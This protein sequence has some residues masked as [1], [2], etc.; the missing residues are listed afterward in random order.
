M[1]ATEVIPSKCLEYGTN[2]P[3][4]LNGYI[5]FDSPTF[6]DSLY[7]TGYWNGYAESV[8][9]ASAWNI[10]PLYQLD[11]FDWSVLLIYFGI[12]T[13]LAIY[14]VYRVKQVIE[15]WRYSK[16]PPKPKGEFAESD[17]P[18]VTV[19]LPLFNEMYVVER[20]VQAVNRVLRPTEG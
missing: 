18:H 14:G 17:L 3:T 19:Q 10:S 1:F 9:Q 2:C 8:Q 5:C 6:C 11:V 16:F 12:L 4:P 20:L 7:K 15:F 13:V